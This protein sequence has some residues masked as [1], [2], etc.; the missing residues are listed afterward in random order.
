MFLLRCSTRDKGLREVDLHLPLHPRLH[1]VRR[2]T[3]LEQVVRLIH[4]VLDREVLVLHREQRQRNDLLHGEALP[5]AS[6]DRAVESRA[7]SEQVPEEA[8]SSFRRAPRALGS[9]AP[10]V[11]DRTPSFD[12]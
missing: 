2:S 7:L 6:H 12:F 8:A 10:A 1:I 5:L 4:D 3:E 11:E 9:V